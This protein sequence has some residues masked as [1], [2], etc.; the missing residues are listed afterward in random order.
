MKIKTFKIK[1]GVIVKYSRSAKEIAR[2]NL[3]EKIFNDMINGKDIDKY[4]KTFYTVEI[5]MEIAEEVEKLGTLVSK[6][7]GEEKKN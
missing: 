7:G 2:K 4:M 3:K 6:L 1:G 5:V